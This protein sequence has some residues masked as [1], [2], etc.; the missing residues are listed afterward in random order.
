M[1]KQIRIHP[2]LKKLCLFI[3]VMILS[4]SGENPSAVFVKITPNITSLPSGQTFHR[5]DNEWIGAAIGFSG[6]SVADSYEKWVELKEGHGATYE[7]YY[8]F[9]SWVGRLVIYDV[10]VID[11]S[12]AYAIITTYENDEGTKKLL[13]QTTV[14]GNELNF[15]NIESIYRFAQDSV[16][17]KDSSENTIYISV[18]ENGLLEYCLYVPIG[19]ADDCSRGVEIDSLFFGTVN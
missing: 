19:C 11:D 12:P 4:C 9:V 13:E 10:L 17:T 6:I 7:Y 16:L 14:Q 15:R 1:T 8:S 2:Y 3:V 5:G 18:F